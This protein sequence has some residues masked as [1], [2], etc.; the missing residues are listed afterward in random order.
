MSPS[1][2]IVA[3]SANFMSMAGSP[4]S[5]RS[6]SRPSARRFS[7][8]FAS[9]GAG[10]VSRCSVPSISANTAA[11]TPAPASATGMPA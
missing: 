5:V 1:C 3:L 9:A 8:S 6:T 11:A 4:S 10:G 7:S 2:S